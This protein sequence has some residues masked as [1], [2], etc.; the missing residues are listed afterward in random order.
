MYDGIQEVHYLWTAPIEAG[1]ILIILAVLV[2][3]YALPGW[4]V[5]CIVLPMQYVFGWKIIK[6]K[7][8]NSK[9]T[10]VIAVAGSGVIRSSTPWSG[11]VGSVMTLFT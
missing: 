2:G 11:G 3:I 6:N 7:M 9:N 1:A 8:E 4:G 5:I 10:T